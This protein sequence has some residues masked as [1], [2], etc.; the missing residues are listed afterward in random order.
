M[1]LRIMGK[2][3]GLPRNVD[4]QDGLGIRK[5]LAGTGKIRGCFGFHRSMPSLRISCI[6]GE[7]RSRQLSAG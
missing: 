1:K 4:R 5:R 3:R 7:E 2:A 6:N